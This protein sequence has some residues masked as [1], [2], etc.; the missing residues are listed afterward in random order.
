M[1]LIEVRHLRKEFPDA[2]PVKDM[3]VTIGKGEIVSLIGQSGCGKSTFLRCLNM[4]E[5]PTSGQILIDGTDICDPK[6]DLPSIR[7]RVGMVFQNYALFTHKLVVENLMMAPVDLLGMSRQDAY[8]KALEM[9]DQVGMRDRALRFPQELSGGQRQRVAIAR[10]LMMDPEILLV[11]EPTSALD[12]QMVSE[13]LKVMVDLAHRGLTMVVVTHEMRFARDA[14]TRVLYLRD[15]EVWESGTPEEIFNHPKRKETHDFVFRVK[16]W[17]WQV[18][19]LYP[20][21]PAVFAALE[22]YCQRQFMDNRSVNACRLLV[23]ETVITQLLGAARAEGVKDPD[24]DVNLQAGEGGREMVLTVDYRQ[25]ALRDKLS[26]S[27]DSDPISSAIIRNLTERIEYPEPGLA[28]F[29][30]KER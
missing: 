20:D 10:A 5:T 11:D 4:I 23:E 15:G 17:D 7:R 22:T 6:T 1:S 29:V 3:N 30:I 12:P 27:R 14:S 8:D 25:S 19:S 16:G 28:R 9:L 13:V 2:V 18:D 21:I 26:L 24:V